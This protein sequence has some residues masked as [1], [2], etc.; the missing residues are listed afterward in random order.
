MQKTKLGTNTI[1]F[2]NGQEYHSLK[3]EI[4][5]E[6]CY[7][8][9]TDSPAPAIIDAGANIGLSVFY[10]KKIY[11]HAKIIA[12]EPIPQNFSLLEQ[13]VFENGLSDVTVNQVALAASPGEVTLH[14]DEEHNW[15]STASIVEGNWTG[16]QSTVP[17]VVSATTLDKIIDEFLEMGEKIDLLK[18]DIEGSEQQVLIALPAKYL[19]QIDQIICEFHPHPAQNLKKLVDFLQRHGFEIEIFKKGKQTRLKDASGL[20][21]IKA[22]RSNSPSE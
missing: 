21:I 22:R 9:D 6:D 8:F 14:T 11:P 13:N 3:E 17:I 12:L 10:F 7:E 19:R 2:S 20:V 4:F 18:L 16:T 1:Y 5:R 15:H